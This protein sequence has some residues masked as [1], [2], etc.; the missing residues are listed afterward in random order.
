M[1]RR[2]LGRTDLH[3]TPWCLGGNII[4]S[5]LDAERS[6]EV[7]DAYVAAGGNFI[8]TANIY[9]DG[10]SE[11]VIGQWM[12]E[13]GIRDEI[14]LAT[15]VGW[16]ARPPVHEQ[17][18]SRQAIIDGIHSSL[19]RLQTDRVDLY[20]AHVDDPA[21]PFTETLSAFDELRSQGLI[22]WVGASNYSPARLTQALDASAARGLAQF[23]CL[24]VKYNLVDRSDYEL[25]MRALC[26]SRSM[27]VTT[28]FS[29]ARGFLSGKYA[30][31]QALPDSPR[32]AAVA[33]N[34]L[35]GSGFEILDRVIEVAQRSGLTPTQ[36]SLAWL[37][38]QSTVASWVSAATSSAQVIEQAAAA[39]A[40]LSEDDL[41]FLSG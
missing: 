1:I 30:R 19:R 18:L 11:L 7:L 32:S 39:D 23:E 35:N 21:T 41:A 3:V 29:L 31:G 17:G 36:V 8:D 20:Y 28:Y 24:Q 22:R 14:V 2:Q 12:R 34:Y 9:G 15:K 10:R 37:L 16:E 13:R 40:R 25:E 33:S 38:H 26:I 6:M 5:T 4:G 27:P